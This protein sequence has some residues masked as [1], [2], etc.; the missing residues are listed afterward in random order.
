MDKGSSPPPPPLTRVVPIES[1]PSDPAMY[2]RVQ[3]A[4]QDL[5]TKQAIRVVQDNSPGFYSRVFMVPKKDSHKWRPVI[6]L[7]AMNKYSAIPHF[8]METSE[9]IRAS[10]SEDEW[11]TS[12]DLQDAYFPYANTPQ[13]QEIFPFPVSRCVLRISGHAV[14]LRLCTLRILR[15]S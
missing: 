7:S 3:G 13:I 4:V 9:I 10:L 14:W 11:T 8:K 15:P 5:M 1:S 6:D 12:V 2:D